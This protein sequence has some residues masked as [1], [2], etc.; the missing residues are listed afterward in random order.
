MAASFHIAGRWLVSYSL[1]RWIVCVSR[2]RIAYCRLAKPGEPAWVV[3]TGT[4]VSNP[5]SVEGGS[6][7]GQVDGSESP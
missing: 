5:G 6:R 4:V 7:I 1:V 3:I 2:P